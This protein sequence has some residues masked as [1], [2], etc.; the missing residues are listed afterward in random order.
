MPI[1]F[2]L[3]Q[4]FPL[5]IIFLFSVLSCFGQQ[6]PSDGDPVRTAVEDYYIKGLKTRDFSLIEYI[7]IPETM[8]YG[9]RSNGNLGST[10]LERWS[11]RF[12]PENPPFKS[13][14]S[15]ITRVDVIG[16]TAQV[17][18]RFTMDGRE[19]HDL[20]NMLLIEGRWRIV[21]IID[22]ATPGD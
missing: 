4:L 2:K 15:E 19:I 13:L 14:E 10:T 21:N 20:L 7:C 9:V 11:L 8:L 18:I 1:R 12:D 5:I 22:Y 16:T 17:K 6:D 3:K